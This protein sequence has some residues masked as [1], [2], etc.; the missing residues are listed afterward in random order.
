MTTAPARDTFS[1]MNR[2]YLCAAI[3]SAFAIAGCSSGSFQVASSTEVDG[4]GADASGD[5]LDDSD[6]GDAPTDGPCVPNG[7]G[8]CR[9]LAHKEGE[10]CGDCGAWVCRADK[11][12]VRCQD[13]GKNDCGGCAI[14]GAKPGDPCASCGGKL[15]CNGANALKCDSGGPKNACGGCSTLTA[16]PGAACGTCGGKFACVGTDSIS[17]AGAKP[18]NACGGCSTLTGAIGDACGCG[19][20]LACSGTDSFTCVGGTPPN[21]CGGCA[22]LPGKPGTRCGSC[23][24]WV[25]GDKDNV[26]CA[27]GCTALEACCSTGDPTTEKCYAKSCLACCSTH[28]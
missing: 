6:P 8:G 7:C 21:D 5:S 2:A 22:N 17:C 19:G 26:N 27:N 1:V 10:P 3:A 14:L 24:R 18:L 16:T 25:C 12:S 4:G 15:Q 9:P 13:L 20:L 23:A 11:E 28:P